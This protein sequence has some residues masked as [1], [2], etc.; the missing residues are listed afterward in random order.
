MV[1]DGLFHPPLS[2]RRILR[3]TLGDK[4]SYTVS[5][6]HSLENLPTRTDSYAAIVIY[7]HHKHISETALKR[8]DR[9]VAAGGGLLGV[10]SATASFKQ[11]SHYFEILGGRFIGHGPVENYT[12]KPIGIS[13]IFAGIP[14]F[15]VFDELYLHDCNPGIEVHYS[16]LYN[17]EKVPAVWSHQ[18]G[19]GRVCYA[20][21][22]H[23]TD[24]LKIEA[25]RKLLQRGL[26]WVTNK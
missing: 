8:L 15:D 19:R 4:K 3:R 24:T 22:G 10:H 23:R 18:Y 12:V 6:I 25:Y 21:P 13:P 5:H 9:F 16:I 26:N 17:G 11:T 20:S 1:T 7:L 2:A 14:A